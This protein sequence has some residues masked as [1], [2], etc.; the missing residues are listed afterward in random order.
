MLHR[1]MRQALMG[2]TAALFCAHAPEM[3][4]DVGRA[5]ATTAEAGIWC[6]ATLCGSDFQAVGTL[7]VAMRGPLWEAQIKTQGPLTRLIL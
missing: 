3:P 6:R 4:T 7:S 1:T 2:S 5:P